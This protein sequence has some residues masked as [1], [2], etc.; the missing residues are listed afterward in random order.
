MNKIKVWGNSSLNKIKIEGNCVISL[1]YV[2]HTVSFRGLFSLFD[3]VGLIICAY[4]GRQGMG[5]W[6]GRILAYLHVFI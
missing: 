3:G 6:G 1:A 2:L 4:G 5:R